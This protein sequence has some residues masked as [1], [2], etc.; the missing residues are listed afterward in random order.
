MEPGLRQLSIYLSPTGPHKPDRESRAHNNDVAFGW[1]AQVLT[2][3]EL[4]MPVPYCTAL[5]RTTA[6]RTAGMYH[7]TLCRRVCTTSASVLTPTRLFALE[8]SRRLQPCWSK[9]NSTPF[10]APTPL[11]S[12]AL[13]PTAHLPRSTASH[14]PPIDSDR[15]LYG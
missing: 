10:F 14:A 8:T 12:G 1:H 7:Q 4:G 5:Y 11:A 9:R 13:L 15:A 3:L 6:H 2:R